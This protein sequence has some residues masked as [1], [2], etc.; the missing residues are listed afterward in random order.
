MKQWIGSQNATTNYFHIWNFVQMLWYIF[1]LLLLLIFVCCY[2]KVENISNKIYLKFQITFEIWFSPKQRKNCSLLKNN[3]DVYT[4]HTD[5]SRVNGEM[6]EITIEWE[7]NNYNI[8]IRIDFDE[9]I[10]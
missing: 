4:V 6:H 10:K 8:Q 5:R 1:L 7:N 9:I 2:Y 3:I